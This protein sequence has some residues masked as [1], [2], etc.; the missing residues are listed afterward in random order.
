MPDSSS[1]RI[2]VDVGASHLRVAICDGTVLSDLVEDRVADLESL[3]ASCGVRFEPAAR[4]VKM[5]AEE[6]TFHP[7]R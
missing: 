2:A 5:A 3:T 1:A 6:R 7:S 4:L